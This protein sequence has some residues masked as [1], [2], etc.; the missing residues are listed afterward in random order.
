[1][2]PLSS[3]IVI[4]ISVIVAVVSGCFITNCPP[5]GKRSIG[6]PGPQRDV[7]YRLV[8]SFY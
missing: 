8:L 6:A 3:L 1:M 4:V 5:G 2:N 7:S